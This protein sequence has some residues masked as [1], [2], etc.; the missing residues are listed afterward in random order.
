MRGH[1]SHVYNSHFKPLEGRGDCYV[2]GRITSVDISEN[3]RGY[4]YYVILCSA[5]IFS[6]VPKTHRIGQKICVPM[7]TSMDFDERV[8]L[9]D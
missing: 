7:E 3:P 9:I 2:E 4:A 6:G 5:D 8:A 1:G